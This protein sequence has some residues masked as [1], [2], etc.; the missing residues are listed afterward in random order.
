[1]PA[2]P[3]PTP[4]SPSRQLMTI[5]LFQNR[6]P[7][8]NRCLPRIKAKP[9][10][11]P[12]S[13]PTPLSTSTLFALPYKS[14]NRP[15]LYISIPCSGSCC[16]P[17]LV[18]AFFLVGQN[19]SEPWEMGDRWGSLAGDWRY[20][21]GEAR[22]RNSRRPPHPPGPGHILVP[23][24]VKK[25]YN[26]AC[27]IKLKTLCEHQRYASMYKNVLE[28]DDSAGLEAFQN[29]KARFFAQYHDR[30]CDIPLP[31][32]DMYIDEVDHDAPVD[33]E[34]VA[35]LEKQPSES[36][37]VQSVAPGLS[38]Y[39]D[40]CGVEAIQP[41]GWD[42]EV[43]PE[44]KRQDIKD[45]VGNSWN[46]SGGGHWDE[47]AAQNDPWSNGRNNWADNGRNISYGTWEKGNSKWGGRNRRKR[48]AGGHWG[49]SFTIPNYQTGAYQAKDSWRNCRRRNQTNY[50]YEKGVYAGQFLT[51]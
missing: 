44:P 17:L 3:N 12:L 30:P 14:S 18:V 49:F 9:P 26:D 48:D 40:M 8:S 13:S 2:K 28:W 34:L 50:H 24:W 25:F 22:G 38:N 20:R 46:D 45:G 41:T 32:P 27:G 19:P 42:D 5:C 7:P 36:T 21:H 1:M 6:K 10:L 37:D 31:D 16:S 15:P 11:L 29:A 23:S 4:K 47:A 51:S 39:W 33:P 43:E 35:D